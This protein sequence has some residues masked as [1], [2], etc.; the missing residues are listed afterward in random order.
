MHVERGTADGK[1]SAAV[2]PGAWGALFLLT[3]MMT[4]NQI[5]RRVA[6]LVIEPLKHEFLL[7][8]AQ[9]GMLTGLAFGMIY[10]LTSIPLGLVADRTNRSRMLAIVVA[11]WSAMT[12]LAGFATTYMH[13]LLT[14]IGVGAAEAGA[15]PTAT[16]IITDLFPRDRR[17]TAIAIYQTGIPIG[18]FLCFIVGAWI[19]AH[20]GWRAAFLA[21]GLPGIPLALL[22]WFLLKE[23]KRGGF[24][25]APPV[26]EGNWKQ[27]LSESF[28]FIF[29]DSRVF[30]LMIGAALLSAANTGVTGWFVPFLMRE[31]GMTIQNAGLVIAFASGICGGIGLIFTGS[32]A[33]RLAKGDPARMMLLCGGIALLTMVLAVAA[34]MAPSVLLTIV[35]I[36]AYSLFCYSFLGISYGALLNLTPASIR[37]TVIAVEMV[38]A[39][40]FGYGGGPFVVGVLS[41]IYGGP[42]SLKWAMVTLNIFYLAGAICFLLAA[43]RKKDEAVAA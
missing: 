12:A 4:F 5:D 23:P 29:S 9:L 25:Q 22:I 3:A 6:S 35:A 41:D 31:H 39:N 16:S 18:S 43:R 13:L 27:R 34:L 32:L 40:L 8:D 1:T 26:L 7:T 37:G 10:A 24:D 38:M 19:V 20:Y 28:R 14:R 36:S 21:A 33:D 30:L 2:K 17:A 15:S 42:S 11:I